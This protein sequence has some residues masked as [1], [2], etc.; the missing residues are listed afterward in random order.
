M[1]KNKKVLCILLI[2]C[3]ILSL[4]QGQAKGS[5]AK[6][7]KVNMALLTALHPKM[8]LFDFQRMGFLKI[9]F[10][11]NKPQVEEQKIILK[12]DEKTLR[13]A[14]EELKAIE[15]TIANQ[16]ALLRDLYEQEGTIFVPDMSDQGKILQEKLSIEL[17]NLIIK[18]Q[19]CEYAVKYPEF[20]PPA[21]TRKILELIEKE[22]IEAVEN[23]AKSNN[24]DVVLNTSTP[25]P[26]GY[27]VSYRPEVQYS[28]GPVGMD[29]INYYTILSVKP[30][31]RDE[32]AQANEMM[33]EWLS[34]LFRPAPQE[35]IPVKPWPLVM[36]GG[37]DILPDALHSLYIKYNIDNETFSTVKNVLYSTGALN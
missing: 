37:T 14:Q 21:E 31:D 12:T 16:E 19:E 20:T 24:F 15:E 11:L 18:R 29:Q 9:S 35:M 17:K 33:N 28:T 3:G 30:N 23:V 1:K 13:K 25:V 27:P 32:E 6:I 4:F 22:T 10:G 8:A 2:C 7:A 36:Q 26:Y 5:D 34:V